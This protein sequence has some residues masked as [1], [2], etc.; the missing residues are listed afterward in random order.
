M[1]DIAQAELQE[2]VRHY[3]GSVAEAEKRMVGEYSPEA[4]RSR[5]QDA[6]VAQIAERSMPVHDLDSLADEDLS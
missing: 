4:H 6:F 1:V 5:M 3:T 2:L